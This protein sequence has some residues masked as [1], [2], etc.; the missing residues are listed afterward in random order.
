MSES[1]EKLINLI[2]T[3]EEELINSH[4]SHIDKMVGII[5][6]EMSIL[7]DVDQPGSDVDEYTS[8]LKSMLDQE[9]SCIASIQ[10]KLEAFTSHLRLEEE[11]SKKFY[12]LQ[13][14]ILDLNDN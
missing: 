10:A 4:R 2:L 12:K 11:M 7:H 13:S 6:G 3:E 9:V 5:K 8:S 14:E 1:H